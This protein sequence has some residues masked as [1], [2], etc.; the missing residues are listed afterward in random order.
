MASIAES[1]DFMSGELKESSKVIQLEEGTAKTSEDDIRT[2]G[3]VVAVAAVAALG[4]LIFGYD[5]GGAGMWK[6]K[7]DD[8]IL[9]EVDQWP[10]QLS[11]VSFLYAETHH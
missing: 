6:L 10:G 9:L 7:Y 4:G 8:F 2:K 3:F 5:I 11:S 1:Y